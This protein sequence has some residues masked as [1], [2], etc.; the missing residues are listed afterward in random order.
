M[1]NSVPMCALSNEKRCR[2]CS[3]GMLWQPIPDKMRRQPTRDRHM[4]KR[5]QNGRPP[6]GRP[7]EL[8]LF[9]WGLNTDRSARDREGIQPVRIRHGFGIGI[10]GQL[11]R[12]E[13]D[14]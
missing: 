11:F 3:R 14:V 13:V 6:G 7:L 12:E 9:D 1:V 2:F 4:S 8:N 10:P 5:K